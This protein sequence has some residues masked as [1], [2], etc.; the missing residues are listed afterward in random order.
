M[1]PFTLIKNHST[2]ILLM[3]LILVL[4][5]NQDDREKLAGRVLDIVNTSLSND[6]ERQRN[7][8]GFH[9]SFSYTWQRSVPPYAYGP[10]GGDYGPYA[11]PKPTADTPP[12]DDYRNMAQ[13]GVEAVP[14]PSNNY[15]QDH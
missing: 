3:V 13:N 8:K 1:N 10:Y 7:N 14:Q 5:T 6:H 12:V 15:P 4:M 11:I 2:T 9:G